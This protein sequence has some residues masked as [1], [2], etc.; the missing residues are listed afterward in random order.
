MLDV[1]TARF[2]VLVNAGQVDASDSLF[3]SQSSRV[4]SSPTFSPVMDNPCPTQVDDATGRAL[5]GESFGCYY[6]Y[7]VT[8]DRQIASNTLAAETAYNNN[9]RILS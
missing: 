8:L 7:C 5:C 1:C 6:D 3:T 9:R 4:T 2:N